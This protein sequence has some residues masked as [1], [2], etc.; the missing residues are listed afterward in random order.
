MHGV[1]SEGKKWKGEAPDVS[2]KWLAVGAA[3]DLLG[4]AVLT[5]RE[6]GRGWGIPAEFGFVSGGFAPDVC[7]T[8][9]SRL[10]GNLG[11]SA[12]D[13]WFGVLVPRFGPPSPQAR[14]HVLNVND[15][16]LLGP[17]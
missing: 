17:R 2:C 9:S 11:F 3:R 8:A 10:N 4:A 6:S 15:D 1:R 7:E 14:A 16:A 13:S 12:H 5:R